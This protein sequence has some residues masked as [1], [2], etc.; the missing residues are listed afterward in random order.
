MSCNQYNGY[1]FSNPS[2]NNTISENKI[3]NNPRWGII[4]VSREQPYGGPSTGNKII[5]NTIQDNG[6]ERST[7]PAYG[8]DNDYGAGVWLWAAVDNSIYGKK[9][10]HNA[11]QVFIF[12]HGANSWSTVLPTGGNFWSDYDGADANGDGIGDSPYLIDAANSDPLPLV[13]D[14]STNPSPDESP[15]VTPTSGGS[16]PIVYIVAIAALVATAVVLLLVFVGR[17]RK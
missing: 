1:Y 7:I 6:W 3:S 15:D 4:I 10:V 8:M 14:S 17:K 9:F 2:F 11:Q 5:G 13:W 12:D 16:L